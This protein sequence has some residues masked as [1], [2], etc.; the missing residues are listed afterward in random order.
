MNMDYQQIPSTRDKRV[1]VII[2]AAGQ[3][4]ESLLPLSGKSSAAMIPLNGK[5]VIYWTLSYLK[6]LGLTKFVIAVPQTNSFVQRFVNQVFNCSL[7][8]TFITP[9]RNGGVGYTVLSCSPAI[10]TD[11]VLIVLGDTFFEFPTPDLANV[12]ESFVLVSAV[13]EYYRWCMAEADENDHVRMLIDKPANYAGRGKA[14]IGV[15]GI[16]NW[17]LFSNCLLKQWQQFKQPATHRM[18]L[19]K[20]LQPYSEQCPLHTIESK[21]WFDCGNPDNLIRSRRKL[22]QTR[23][24]NYME[25][26]EVLGTITKRS[27]HR[28]KFID[29][30]R[31]Y[32]NLPGDIRVLFP[33]VVISNCDVENPFL[34][35]EYYGY[36][37][38]AE[39]F[40]FENIDLRIWQQV[41]E[42]LL[43]IITRMATYT[44]PIDKESF[45]YMYIERTQERVEKLRRTKEIVGHVIN[46]CPELII[47][48]RSRRNFDCLWQEIRPRLASLTHDSDYTIIHGDMCFSNILYDLNARLC[49][50]VD[51]RGSF[52]RKGIHGDIKYDIAKLYHSAHGLYDFITNDLFNIECHDNHIQYEVYAGETTTEV[53]SMFETVFFERFDRTEIMLIEGLL[54][55]TMGIFHYDKPLRQ[56]AMYT[57]GIEIW[58]EV[59]DENLY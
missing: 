19:S 24:F 9:D 22:S 20:G 11:R 14:L 49:K 1:T 58:N 10:H 5:P 17:S 16:T 44:R 36:P 32:D 33:R 8:I 26:D 12:N 31:Y 3:V 23:D 30:I 4:S 28:E 41:F 40:V 27:K 2:P 42:H 56:L 52:G 51:P 15:Y 39:L 29:E 34:T 21:Q 47:N 18:E 50:F 35:M 6:Q 43:K 37:T 38:L 7:D 57:T 48:G 54:F 46:E 25:F 53:R 45:N 59:L 55:I 13:K